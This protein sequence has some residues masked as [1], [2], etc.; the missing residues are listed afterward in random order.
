MDV[1]NRHLDVGLESS[2]ERSRPEMF[3]RFS[4]ANEY[5]QPHSSSWR[6]CTWFW[7][8]VPSLKTYIVKS[9]ESSSGGSFITCPKFALEM[10]FGMGGGAVFK[11]YLH[12]AE[13]HFTYTQDIGC[14]TERREY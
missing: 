6:E 11:V 14:C 9:A 12:K 3:G 4:T 13:T 2:E 10:P 8:P 5:H 7:G 1:A